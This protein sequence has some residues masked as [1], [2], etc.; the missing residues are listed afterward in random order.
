[1]AYMIRVATA[2]LLAVLTVCLCSCR[3]HDYHTVEIHVPEMSNHACAEI[4]SKAAHGEVARCR[5][6]H[7]EK[8]LSVDLRTRT[9]TV[10][11][12]SLKLAL[13]NI[14]FAIADAGFATQDV[15]ANKAA[16][17]K[18]PAECRPDAGAAT[19]MPATSAPPVSA[20]A[21]APAGPRKR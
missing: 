21:P 16:A 11:Y 19:N 18:L 8:P 7:P 5:A 10:T 1:M 3:R 17:E 13:K 6:L 15:P 12:D 20:K 9:V 2:I 4:V 14:E